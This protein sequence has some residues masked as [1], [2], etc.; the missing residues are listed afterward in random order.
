MDNHIDRKT[1]QYEP[2]AKICNSYGL[3]H[4]V[5]DGWSLTFDGLFTTNKCVVEF[6][7]Q[8]IN[9]FNSNSSV[10]RYS[11]GVTLNVYIHYWNE[12]REQC[13]KNDEW[14]GR[15]QSAK[16]TIQNIPYE[17]LDMAYL[18]NTL[19]NKNVYFMDPAI[20]EVKVLDTYDKYFDPLNNTY[21]DKCYSDTWDTGGHWGN[22]WGDEGEITPE[23]QPEFN[24]FDELLEKVAPDISHLQYKRLYREC[25]TIEE[26][27]DVGYYG[28]YTYYNRYVL[29][30]KK[31]YEML[32]EMGYIKD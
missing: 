28:S 14:R 27:T 19:M 8:L 2:V 31:C 26:G 18:K 4:Y 25:V 9:Y 13:I 21:Q 23:P 5:R 6:I 3:D 16:A 32:K 10:L 7:E 22:C 1:N 15:E 24:T 11:G 29:D 30:L 12:N 20:H 17:K